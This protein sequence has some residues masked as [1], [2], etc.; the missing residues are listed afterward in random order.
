MS[1]ISETVSSLDVIPGKVL[2]DKVYQN[3]L[4]LVILVSVEDGSIKI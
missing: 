4:L 1:L 2:Y 3:N